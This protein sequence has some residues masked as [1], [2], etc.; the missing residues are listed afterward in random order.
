MPPADGDGMGLAPVRE[1]DVP[2]DALLPGA[3]PVGRTVAAAG[4][5]LR[6][7]ACVFDRVPA[8]RGIDLA[9]RPGEFMAL[10]GP[11]GAGKTTLLRIVAGLQ[12]PTEGTL[13]IGG[14]DVT[15]V[16][17]RDRNIGFV[18]QNYALFRHMTV[19]RNVAFGLTVR[20]RARR[21][22]RRA[23]AARV[24]EL[25]ELVQVAPLA[26]RYPAQLS[27]GQRQRVALARALAT[28]PSLL[29]LDEPFGALD[30]LVRK[31]IRTWL[32]ALHDRLGLTSVMVTHDQAEALEV[33][34]R[35]AVLRDGRLEQVGTPA[36]LEDR[37]ATPFVHQFLGETVR[38]GA[39]IDADGQLRLDPPW[40]DVPLFGGPRLLPAPGAVSLSLRP[41]EVTLRPVGDPGAARVLSV[42]RAGAH[43][44]LTVAPTNDG[45][46]TIEVLSPVS[47]PPLRVGMT[48]GLDLSHARCFG[49]DDV[50]QSNASPFK[51]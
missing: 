17:A 2:P 21:P 44:R 27:G 4:V 39:T 3:L 18:F 45:S 33:A 13:R 46:S 20:P 26:R 23:I 48:C 5:E 24:A 12:P 30:P 50:G 37:P 15:S 9:V 43:H 42:Q 7:V 8:V 28:E 19:E 16:P 40:S 34:D 1:G 11:S 22:N 31:E 35:I 10:V 14:R 51:P 41:Y 25:L 38:F 32:R 49:P 6:S 29:L 36:E 47:D